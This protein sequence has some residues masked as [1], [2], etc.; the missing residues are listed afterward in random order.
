MFFH[1]FR[2]Y[3]KHLEREVQKAA[4]NRFKDLSLKL[5]RDKIEELNV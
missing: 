4:S 2:I 3:F 1:L 5:A